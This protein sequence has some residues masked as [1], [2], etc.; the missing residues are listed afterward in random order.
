MAPSITRTNHVSYSSNNMGSRSKPFDIYEGPESDLERTKPLAIRADR[1]SMRT[2]RANLSTCMKTKTHGKTDH[3]RVGDGTKSDH[4][5]RSGRKT[6]QSKLKNKP[7]G[8]E[9][10]KPRRSARLEAKGQRTS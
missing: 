3:L 1:Q 7:K 9:L 5:A 8:G 6:K 4:K 2:K 10:D